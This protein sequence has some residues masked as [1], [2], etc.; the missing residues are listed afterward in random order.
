[1]FLFII[2]FADNNN[3]DASKSYIIFEFYYKFHIRIF[4]QEKID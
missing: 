2:V 1:M 3:K 4:F